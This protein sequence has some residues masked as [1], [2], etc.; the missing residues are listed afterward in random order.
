[1]RFQMQC[2]AAAMAVASIAGGA[3]VADALRAYEK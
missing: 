2:A 1:M 3:S